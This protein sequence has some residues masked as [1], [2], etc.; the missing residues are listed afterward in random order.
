MKVA[1]TVVW[2]NP[3]NENVGN[4]K[5]YIDYV[6]KL[7]IVDNS[8]K[9]NRKLS[10]KLNNTKV[11]YIYNKGKNLGI[12]SALNLVCEKAKNENFSWMLTMDQDSSF[13]SKNMKKYIRIFNLIQNNN[14][15]IISPKHILKNDT[16]E[17]KNDRIFVNTD[18]VMTSGN[19]LNLLVWEKVGKFDE[20]LF[21]DEVDSEMCY[22]MIR[23]GYKIKQLNKIKM[24]HELGN[25]EKR[26]FFFRKISILNHNYIRKYY[27]MRNK[28]YIFKNYKKYRLRY[29]Y[30]IL[31]DFFK[32][33]F[34]EK[35]KLKKLRYM[36]RGI[37]DFLQDKMGELND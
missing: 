4:I 18:Y 8:K 31:N 36:F 17:Q 24:Y 26:N 11:E 25:L 29:G 27:I 12:S 6:E 33:I 37:K 23:N 1:G 3:N 9:N 10:E 15:G 7:Y 30:Y 35:D 28:F 20:K 13:D 2:Y 14:T 5:T 34:Y 22:K 21:I 19:L 16:T 32:V